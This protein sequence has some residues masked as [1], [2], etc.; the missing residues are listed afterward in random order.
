MT[1]P[2]G[3]S[4]EERAA[5]ER[6]AATVTP[7]R[8]AHR[9]K[10]AGRAA[11]SDAAPSPPPPPASHS[12]TKPAKLPPQ[13]RRVAPPPPPKPAAP[14]PAREEAGLDSHWDRRFRAGSIAPDFTLDLHGHT[15]DSAHA[16][17][18]DGLAQAKAMDARV[19]LLI[20]GRSRPVDAADRGSRR[21]AIRAKVLD[22]LAAGPHGTDIAAIRKAHRRHGGEGALYLILKRRR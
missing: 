14:V 13:T 18:D 7:L 3:L 15:L 19:V 21:G 5:W 1:A 16:R 4:E 2:R 8:P 20:A 22:W 9:G 6:L 17:L 12:A 11:G 10:P